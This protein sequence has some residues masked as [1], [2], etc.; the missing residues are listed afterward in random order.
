MSAEMDR[1]AA[2]GLCAMLVS[3]TLEHVGSH[4]PMADRRTW[5]WCPNPRC[6]HDEMLCLQHY[7]LWRGPV[8]RESP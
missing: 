8:V 6:D 1:R 4:G 2:R 3:D 5:R 7:R